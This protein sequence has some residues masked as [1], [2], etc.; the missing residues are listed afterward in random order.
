MSS[1]VTSDDV[2]V[3][4]DRGDARRDRGVVG[5]RRRGRQPGRQSKSVEAESDTDTDSCLYCEQGDLK[6]EKLITCKD[7]STTGI[8]KE[9]MLLKVF[10]FFTDFYQ[11]DIR[12][13]LF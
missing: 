12:I 2:K 8:Y 6:N 3:K 1:P 4:R 11:R 13:C 5:V 10:Y 7:C 9:T